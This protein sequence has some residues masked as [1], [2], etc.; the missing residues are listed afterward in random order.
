MHLWDTGGHEK[1]RSMMN[2]YYRDAIGAIIC[3]DI[4]NAQSFEAVN[5]WINEMMQNTSF[6]SGGFMMALVGNK[7]DLPEQKQKI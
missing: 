5:Y 3:Y 7:S 4:G 6:G 1:F 2:L